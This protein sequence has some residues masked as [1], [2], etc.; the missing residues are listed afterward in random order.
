M[1]RAALWPK[2]QTSP[3]SRRGAGREEIAPL[4]NS[5]DSWFM[6]QKKA[7]ENE[8]DEDTRVPFPPDPANLQ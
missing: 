1:C 7:K 5:E 3:N 2:S 4:K 6:Q 8:E